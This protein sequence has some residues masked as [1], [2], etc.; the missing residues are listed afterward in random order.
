MSVSDIGMISPIKLRT[1]YLDSQFLDKPNA[2]NLLECINEAI[3]GLEQDK[4]LQLDMDGPSVNWNVLEMLNDSLVE[5][6]FTKTIDIGSYAQHIVHGSL[7][8]ILKAMFWWL[9]D[10]PARR[11]I[12]QREGETNTFPLRYIN[13]FCCTVCNVLDFEIALNFRYNE[14]KGT[15]HEKFT[16]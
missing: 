6:G 3:K 5:K 14:S 13:I 2:D 15:Y 9:H 11:G 8:K 10:S 4:L 1:R 12:Y 16:F 7:D